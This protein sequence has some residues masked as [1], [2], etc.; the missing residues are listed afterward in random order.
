ML[1][2]ICLK[3]FS[4]FLLVLTSL[5]TYASQDKENGFYISP[6][7]IVA[8]SSIR[9]GKVKESYQEPLILY[10]DQNHDKN[11]NNTSDI[12]GG[13]LLSLGYHYESWRAELSYS[14]RY[15]FDLNG[16]V[17]ELDFDEYHNHDNLPGHFRLDINTQ[18]VRFDLYYSILALETESLKPFIGVSVESLQH[19][20]LA[21]V[22]NAYNY[23]EE[24]TN[25]SSV[26][27]GFSIG[28]EVIMTKDMNFTVSLHYIDLGDIDIGPQSDNAYFSTDSFNTI[29]LMFGVNYY[30]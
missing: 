18:S 6:K 29:D 3:V 27:L 25:I 9:G 26:S 2:I 24:N 10:T 12:V 16:D 21:K 22:R 15:R 13:A 5:S 4:V 11:D 23:T 7:L 17:G 14:Y 30:F 8:H 1:K 28:T 20:I 19:N